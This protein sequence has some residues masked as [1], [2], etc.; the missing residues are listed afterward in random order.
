VD[1]EVSRKQ[2][3]L[4]HLGLDVGRQSGAEA[5]LAGSLTHRSPTVGI[6]PNQA[7]QELVGCRV[8]NGVLG[9]V[10]PGSSRI[11]TADSAPTG[12]WRTAVDK[13]LAL[14]RKCL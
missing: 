5:T 3:S 4:V 13:L 12:G 11:A 6:G 2:L 14:L 10:E 9:E 1:S 8:G 7:W